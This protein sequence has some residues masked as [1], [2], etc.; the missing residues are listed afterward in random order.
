MR[1]VQFPLVNPHLGLIWTYK[2][3]GNRTVL[4]HS[5]GDPGVST[6]M[7]YDVAAG[8]GVV[9]L[10][11]GRGGAVGAKVYS[12]TMARIEEYLLDQFE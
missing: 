2:T 9:V 3:L 11:N 1:K 5:G 4:G 12:E 8:V 7:G 10:T 6:Y